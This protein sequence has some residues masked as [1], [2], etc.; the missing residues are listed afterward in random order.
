MTVRARRLIA[1]A[2]V[3]VAD[4]LGPA[5]ELLAELPADVLRIDVG[6]EPGSHP[7]P[8]E[9]INELLVAHAR[10]G[11]RVVRLKGGD[12]FVFGRGGE[13]VLA[14]VAAGIP[15]DVVPGT[16]S[17]ISV[18][19]AAGIP[20]THR[21]TAM[22][23]HVV[24]GQA[25]VTPATLAALADDAVTTVILMGVRALPRIAE[26]ARRAGVADDRPVAIIENGH[27]PSQRT[28]H[29]TLGHA[30]DEARAVG[31]RNP[32][33]IVVGDVARAGFLLPAPAWVGEATR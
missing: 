27:T 17:A 30:A 21:G 9:E 23:F 2:D 32:A 25:E 19:Q 7:V 15:V 16:S 8:Q 26:A 29:T 14:C 3:V 20:V 12:P 24:N 1:E 18:P 22:A 33:V 13:E 6:K 4:R 11:K 10:A 28:T 5:A 31:V